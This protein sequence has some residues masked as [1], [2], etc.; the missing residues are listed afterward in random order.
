[1]ALADALAKGQMTHELRRALD[2]P[3][4]RAAHWYELIGMIV[5]LFLMAVKSSRF[6][7]NDP[8]FW[9]ILLG[10][11]SWRSKEENIRELRV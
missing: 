10:E 5:V 9:K 11:D 7:Q 1:M 8:A 4:V 3:V 2:D 6:S